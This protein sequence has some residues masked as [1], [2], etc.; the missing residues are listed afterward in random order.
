MSD[1]ILQLSADEFKDEL[2]SFEGPIA[3]DF[4]SQDCPPFARLAPIYEKMA[5][6]AGVFVAGD[7]RS[8]IVRQVATA[9]ADGAVPC[10]PK[11]ELK[12]VYVFLAKR[13]KNK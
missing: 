12:L 13:M 8:K 6:L 3:L 9:V 7:V 10:E 4:F 2:Q 5:D 11:V 1:R